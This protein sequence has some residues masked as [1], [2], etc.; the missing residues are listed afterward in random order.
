[1]IILVRLRNLAI[2]ALAVLSVSFIYIG[3]T[4]FSER[5]NEFSPALSLVEEEMNQTKATENDTI[6]SQ[7]PLEDLN[8][9]I[10]SEEKI[11]RKIIL[12]NFE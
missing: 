6:E 3:Y 4:D 9:V 1:M 2:F 10:S 11:S 12:Q 7:I 8:I 5:G